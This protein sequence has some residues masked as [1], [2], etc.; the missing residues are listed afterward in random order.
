MRKPWESPWKPGMRGFQ[1][2]MPKK[3][4][5]IFVN[6][7]LA[8]KGRFNA[9]FALYYKKGAVF[10]TTVPFSSLFGWHEIKKCQ[11][12]P[13]KAPDYSADVIIMFGKL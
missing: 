4:Q 2:Q 3:K 6:M 12:Y 13:Y 10:V 5:I 8:M 1:M 9:S 7:H 11:N